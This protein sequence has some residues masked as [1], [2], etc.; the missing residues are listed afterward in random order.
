MF[1]KANYEYPVNKNVEASAL[2]KSWGTFKEDSLA[3]EEL[4]KNNSKA[5]KIFNEVNWK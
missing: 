3:L 4:G 2:L 1:A 5:V